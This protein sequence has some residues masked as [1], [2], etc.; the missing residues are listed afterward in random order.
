MTNSLPRT[1]EPG[2]CSFEHLLTLRLN[3]TTG[4]DTLISV[5]ASAMS[6]TPDT[7]DV[8]YES[9]ASIIRNFPSKEQIV[10]LGDF[11]AR[12]GAD[13]D[14]W[15]SCLG[16]FG[17]GKMNENEQR[18]LELCTFHDLCIT[19]SFFSTMPQYKASWRHP[20]SKH[21]HQLV[22]ILV[23]RAGVKNILHTHSYLNA[24]YDTDHSLVSC[25]IRM[26]PKKF[27]RTKTRGNP[28]ID[29]SKMS[30]PDLMEQFA[31]TFEKEFGTSQPGDSATEKWEDLRDT[32]YHT[33]LDTFGKKSS[34]SHDWFEAKSTVMTPVT[35]AK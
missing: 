30:Q 12:M 13:H 29:V 7:M 5:Y 20:R 32:I 28:R 21:W 23:R 24:D 15:P 16:Q 34:K 22:F 19:N 11:N 33:A 18:L 17:V 9:L 14:S 27:H 8:F 2:S 25:K 35:E 10:L 1:V 26:Q 4:P 31:Q 3:C 6:T